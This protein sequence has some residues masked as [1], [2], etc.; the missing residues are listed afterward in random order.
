MEVED[1]WKIV[2]N[3]REKSDASKITPI[4]DP[5]NILFTLNSAR[6]ARLDMWALA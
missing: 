4:S 6:P 3:G 1:S 5:L 2:Q